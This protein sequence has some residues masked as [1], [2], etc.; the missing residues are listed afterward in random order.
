[1]ARA[2]RTR[3]SHVSITLSSLRA[4]GYIEDRLGRVEHEIRRRKVYFLTHKGYMRAMELRNRYLRTMIGVF[5]NG[6]LRIMRIEELNGQLEGNFT[7]A[8]ILSCVRDTGVLDLEMLRGE[9][10]PSE[11]EEPVVEHEGRNIKEDSGAV[12]ALHILL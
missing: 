1:M 4:R 9:P 12:A 11:D 2:L 6:H 3:R 8:E 7:L 10:R 5:R